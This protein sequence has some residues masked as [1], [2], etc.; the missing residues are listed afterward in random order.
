MRITPYIF[1]FVQCFGI[2]WVTSADTGARAE[3]YLSKCQES[4]QSSENNWETLINHTLK[5]STSK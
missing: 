4:H 3:S 1:K 5:Q 2:Q